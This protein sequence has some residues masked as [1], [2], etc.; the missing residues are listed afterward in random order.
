MI[1]NAKN[2][3]LPR[4]FSIYDGEI[5]ATADTTSVS[6]TFPTQIGLR[7]GN[8]VQEKPYRLYPPR[9]QL[10]IRGLEGVFCGPC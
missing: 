4:N 3:D 1:R 5:A 9:K 10:P 8:A 7:C 6:V 2:P